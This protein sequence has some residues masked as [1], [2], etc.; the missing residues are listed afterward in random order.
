MY[1]CVRVL[2]FGKGPVLPSKRN[3]RSDIHW[4]WIRVIFIENARLEMIESWCVVSATCT[5]SLNLPS[6][7][8]RQSNGFM[9]PMALCTH[10][11]FLPL[12]PSKWSVS[13]A[14]GKPVLGY[15]RRVA[16]YCHYCQRASHHVRHGWRKRHPPWRSIPFHHPLI[17][18]V[19]GVNV[20][21]VIDFSC[22]SEDWDTGTPFTLLSLL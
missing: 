2:P 3:S 8:K 9:H 4:P 19:C 13:R 22:K 11:P 12:V 6:R 18:V 14:N 17:D 15:W 5:P 16:L 20:S 21:W 7:I 10:T 1:V